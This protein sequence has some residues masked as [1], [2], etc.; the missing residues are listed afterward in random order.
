MKT[1]KVTYLF[2][3]GATSFSVDFRYSE[4]HDSFDEFQKDV[5][6][7]GARLGATWSHMELIEEF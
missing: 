5:E 4:Y 2:G 7:F 3:P 6:D 1:Y